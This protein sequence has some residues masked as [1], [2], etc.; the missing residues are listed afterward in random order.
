MTCDC[1]VAGLDVLGW[2]C[3]VALDNDGKNTVRNNNAAEKADLKRETK[4][5]SAWTKY[6]K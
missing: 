5:G 4:A 6:F 1:G 3:G 2:L